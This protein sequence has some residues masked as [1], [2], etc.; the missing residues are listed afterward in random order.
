MVIFLLF[1]CLLK[2]INKSIVYEK[3]KNNK[4]I[5]ELTDV[6]NWAAVHLFISVV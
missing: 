2:L 5:W 4:H 3:A 6:E 1:S